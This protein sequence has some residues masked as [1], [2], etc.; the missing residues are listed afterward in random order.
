MKRG[1]IAQLPIAKAN[2]Q[3]Q[4]EIIKYV[5]QLLQ[6]NK[7]LQVATLPEQK[8]QIQSRIGYCDDK[9]NEIV[10]GLYGLM[11]E[12]REVIEKK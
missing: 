12:E 1:H 10:Y 5:D 9:I 6:L 4:A 7:E 2:E 11:E 3:Q 8:E